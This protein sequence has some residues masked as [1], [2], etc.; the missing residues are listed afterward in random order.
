MS[1]STGSD[2]APGTTRTRDRPVSGSRL[3]SDVDATKERVGSPASQTISGRDLEKI[4]RLQDPY[5]PVALV[6]TSWFGRRSLENVVVFGDSYSAGAALEV[7]EGGD[8]TGEREQGAPVVWERLKRPPVAGRVEVANYASASARAADDAAH[9][10]AAQ[11]ARYLDGIAYL[12]TPGGPRRSCSRAG[13][14]LFFGAGDCVRSTAAPPGA[15]ERVVGAMLELHVKA[16]ARNFV[17][18]DVPPLERSPEVA[19]DTHAVRERVAGWNKALYKAAAEFP[20]WSEKITVFVVSSHRTVTD[21]LDDPTEYEFEV[22]DAAKE[23]VDTEQPV[24]SEGR[25]RNFDR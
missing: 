13:R 20:A 9:G 16:Q 25:K 1:V 14:L 4:P 8:G 15:A 12:P 11:V 23:G 6:G 5:V 18:V 22:E 21:V 2:P 10:L 19:H 7:P 3:P 24:E 17:L